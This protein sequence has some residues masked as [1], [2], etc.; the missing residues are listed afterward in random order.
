MHAYG[1]YGRP[2]LLRLPLSCDDGRVGRSPFADYS[3]RVYLS[4]TGHRPP[5]RPANMLLYP[6]ML[7]VNAMSF[8]LLWCLPSLLDIQFDGTLEYTATITPFA[9][10]CILNVAFY[11]PIPV[12]Y[13][14][15]GSHQ[16]MWRL[17]LPALA[18]DCVLGAVQGITLGLNLLVSSTS[19]S[20]TN[21]KNNGRS[22]LLPAINL[23]FYAGMCCSAIAV[24]CIP[25]VGSVVGWPLSAVP[26]KCFIWMDMYCTA[27]VPAIMLLDTLAER[28]LLGMQQVQVVLGC[29]LI[30]KGVAT[31][32]AIELESRWA[33]FV[34]HVMSMILYGYPIYALASIDALTEEPKGRVNER[35]TCLHSV[36]WLMS[37][38]ACIVLLS[39]PAA[40]F[41][42]PLSKMTNRAFDAHAG[43]FWGCRCGM[44]QYCAYV[45]RRASC[46]Q[47]NK[48]LKNT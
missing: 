26:A 42:V 5:T 24:H 23:F 15:F 32:V 21:G 9:P 41:A 34:L 20:R 40:L 46:R 28:R 8:V 43:I 7:I 38:T 39:G 27:C 37:A 22:L 31:G 35:T 29:I 18:L 16:E 2:L 36:P 11:E 44:L 1:Q 25:D 45:K 3:F 14:E 19:T 13:I 30:F 47:C 48:S 6:S 12:Q 33:G 10:D 17:N 4:R